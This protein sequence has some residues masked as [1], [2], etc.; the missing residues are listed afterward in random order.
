MKTEIASETEYPFT[1]EQWKALTEPQRRAID[2]VAE[3][4][5]GNPITA[6]FTDQ[7]VTFNLLKV[8][9]DCVPPEE[10]DKD[11]LDTIRK[12]FEAVYWAGMKLAEAELKERNLT[13]LKFCLVIDPSDEDRNG[14]RNSD[15]ELS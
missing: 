12:K 15:S 7:E 2:A 3:Y 9:D 6:G 13:A 8:C 14:P 1:A 10:A 5:T 11:L 4:L